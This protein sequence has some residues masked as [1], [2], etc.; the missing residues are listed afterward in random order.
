MRVLVTGANGFVG[1]WVIRRLL[2][3][4]H[5][6]IGATGPAADPGVLTPEER[7]RVVWAVLELEDPASA[8]ACAALA[9]EAVIH[10]AGQAS[11][12]AS[13]ADPARCWRVNAL[14]TVTLLEAVASRR[15]LAGTDPTVL[16]VSTAEVYG[17]GPTR[18]RRETDAL[19]PV[20]P[21]AASKA[22][23]ELGGLEI[24]RRTGL[25]VLV[26]RP[27]PHTGPGQS[28]RFVVPG[29]IERLL[30]A[31][32]TRASTVRTGNLDP[33]R[34]ILDVRDVADAYVRLLESGTSGEVYNVARGSGLSLREVFQTIAD[35]LGCH[36]TP[37]RDP[38]LARAADIPHLV[39]DPDKLRA[40]TGWVP[41]HTLDHTLQLMID[42]QAD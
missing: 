37:E 22:A 1:G 19:Q 34:D 35:R 27:F 20:S 21:Y 36:A 33:V 15:R 42:A 41:R 6:V 31:R 11:V 14:G 16:V 32:R 18:P 28:T 38:S 12:A 3:G 9:G 40:A 10:L 4:G 5:Q 13:L 30:A 26:A 39:G 17:P 7:A 8:D 23:V 2:A 25:R 24:G 29:F